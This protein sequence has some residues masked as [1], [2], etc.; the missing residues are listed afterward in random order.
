MSRHLR[1]GRQPEMPALLRR[2]A[3]AGTR[4][5]PGRSSLDS[6]CAPAEYSSYQ[7]GISV[8]HLEA[9]LRKS[10]AGLAPGDIL[11]LRTGASGIAVSDPGGYVLRAWGPTKA[12]G[13]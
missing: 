11:L 5:C 2:P 7:E 3:S 6:A 4:S 10:G 1:P 8:A 12:A 9:G 13:G